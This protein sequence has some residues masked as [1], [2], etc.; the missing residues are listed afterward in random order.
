MAAVDALH[1]NP[2]LQRTPDLISPIR[3][4]ATE[5][6]GWGSGTVSK[7]LRKEWKRTEQRCQQCSAAIA[8]LT[9][10]CKCRFDKL[11]GMEQSG[12]E[13]PVN[14]DCSTG[15]R[16]FETTRMNEKLPIPCERCHASGL[17]GGVECEECR[18]KGYCLSV[19]GRPVP[20]RDVRLAST[21]PNRP[22]R[23][24]RSPKRG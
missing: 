16:I 18:G 1:R 21:R 3:Y 20:T 12:K 11:L 8:I 10:T 14:E 2:A 22:K 4:D 15:S 7:P 13:M 6:P 19:D 17:F 5:S 9:R 24:Q 23:W